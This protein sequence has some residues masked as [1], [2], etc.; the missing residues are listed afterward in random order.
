MLATYACTHTHT[1]TRYLH[2]KPHQTGADGARKR[3]FQYTEQSTRVRAEA[4][5]RRARAPESAKWCGQP[6][7]H[8]RTHARLHTHAI[9]SVAEIYKYGFSLRNTLARLSLWSLS[10]VVRVCKQSGANGWWRCTVRDM[11]HVPPFRGAWETRRFQSKYKLQS[12]VTR[13]ASNRSSMLELCLTIE[14]FRISECINAFQNVSGQRIYIDY[15]VLYFTQFYIEGL[16]MVFAFGLELA[17]ALG[18]VG[19]WQ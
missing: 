11:Y 4:E 15:I 13:L 3:N 17:F 8:A 12:P 2:R 10:C 18:L 6:A 14:S 16:A 7:R 19:M 5:T 1:H 9:G